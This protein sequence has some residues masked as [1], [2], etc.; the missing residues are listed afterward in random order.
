LD[1]AVA[2]KLAGADG[3]VAGGGVVDGVGPELPEPQL[4]VSADAQSN[5]ACDF[6]CFM[7]SPV[8]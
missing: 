2:V 5:I 4:A 7:L 8:R 1:D 6:P 3:A